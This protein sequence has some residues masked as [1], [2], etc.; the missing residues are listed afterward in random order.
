MYF[1]CSECQNVV[2]CEAAPFVCPRCGLAGVT[3]TR[4]DALAVVQHLLEGDDEPWELDPL[5]EAPWYVNRPT[6]TAQ[7]R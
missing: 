6:G 7:T 4:V 2:H 1:E 5:D 3:F